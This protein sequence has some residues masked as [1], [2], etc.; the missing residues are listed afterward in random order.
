MMTFEDYK[1]DVLADA[2]GAIEEG[3]EWWDSWE[4]AYD[5]LLLDDAVTGNASGSRTLSAARAAEN[6]RGLLF[7]EGFAAEAAAA[8]Y[9]PELLAMDPET[10]DIV[11]RCLAFGGVSGELRDAFEE[12]RRRA[13]EEGPGSDAD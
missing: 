12:A 1:R 13:G 3:A 5:A 6:A 10:V 2:C 7:D 11:A 8:G 4:E 9:G